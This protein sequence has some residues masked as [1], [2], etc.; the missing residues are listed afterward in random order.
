MGIGNVIFPGN[1]RRRR[2]RIEDAFGSDP[3]KDPYLERVRERLSGIRIYYEET[4]DSLTAG[5]RLDEITWDDLEMD[6]MFLRINQTKCYIGEQVLYRRLHHLEP[7]ED[8]EQF[9]R[10]QAFYESHKEDRIELEEALAQIGKQEEAYYL[11]RFLKHS[12]LCQIGNTAIY[13]VLQ[14]LLVCSILLGIITQSSLGIGAAVLFAVLNLG[15]YVITKNKYEAFL[16]SLLNLRQVIAFCEKIEKEPKWKELVATNDFTG[17]LNSMKKIKRLIRG[18]Q[19]RRNSG[20]TGDP[21]ALLADYLYGITLYDLSVFN[22][23]TKMIEGKQEQVLQLYEFV[24]KVDLS[25]SVASFRA[26]L[27]AVCRPNFQKDL[28]I[29]GEGLYH[30]LI[31]KAVGNDFHMTASSLITGANASGK[32]TFMKALAINVILAQTLHTCAARAL[33]LPPLTVMTSMAVRDD[34][35]SGESYYIRE[36]KYLKRMLEAVDLGVPVLCV[37]DEILKGTNTRE[38]LAAS[39]A[40][41][42]YFSK[43]NCLA[44]AATHDMELVLKLQRH[45]NCYYFESRM[46]EHDIRFDYRIKKGIGGGSNAIKL[47]QILGFPEEVTGMAQKLIAEPAANSSFPQKIQ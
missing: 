33:T 26:S 38:R 7:E 13:H 10:Q 45:Y 18:L 27:V 15:I 29:K 2:A 31:S 4:Q 35:L 41:L 6:E 28:Q 39:E 5:R 11:P 23:I 25:I 9:E 36:V 46:E 8:W 1:Y 17:A 40:V 14:A 43:K 34:L 30:P 19:A 37:I 3:L 24:G 42:H 22:H 12:A 16:H 21:M 44:L 20:M 32:S 47:L